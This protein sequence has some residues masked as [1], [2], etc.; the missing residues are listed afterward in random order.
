MPLIEIYENNF[1]NWTDDV[2]GQAFAADAFMTAAKE[3]PYLTEQINYAKKSNEQVT[4]HTL[5]KAMGANVVSD[6][7]EAAAIGILAECLQKQLEGSARMRAQFD[8]LLEA[9]NE[10]KHAEIKDKRIDYSF[11]GKSDHFKLGREIFGGKKMYDDF[12]PFVIN[13]GVVFPGFWAGILKGEDEQ[14]DADHVFRIYPEQLQNALQLNLNSIG[15]TGVDMVKLGIQLK[16][17]LDV[18]ELAK[19]NMNDK[20]QALELFNDTFTNEPIKRLINKGEFLD[21]SRDWLSNFLTSFDPPKDIFDHNIDKLKKAIEK[22][23]ESIEKRKEILEK[24]QPL[25]QSE[26]AGWLET[27]KKYEEA[28]DELGLVLSIRSSSSNYSKDNLELLTPV[29]ALDPAAPPAASEQSSTQE[30]TTSYR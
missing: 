27:Y 17:E 4:L 12:G 13:L 3:I 14:V 5:A 7:P 28:A 10:D 1:N 2:I 25:L 23:E 6:N 20:Y 24:M 16:N 8:A 11:N 18:L 15:I 26:Y 21:V 30:D 9:Y 22:L 19:D 29:V